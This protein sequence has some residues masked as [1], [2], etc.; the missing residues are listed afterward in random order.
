M[1]NEIIISMLVFVAGLILIIKGA[2]WITKYGSLLAKKLGVSE[3][4]I[5]ITL[6]AMATS[7][8]ELAVAIISAV[9]NVN[10]IATGTVIGSNISN[11]A[12]I[13]GLS[14]LAYPLSTKRK[15]LN[16]GFA[17]LGFS[18]LLV[19]FLF[20]G[21][22]WYEGAVLLLFFFA[23]IGYSLKHRKEI[24]TELSE[25][26][27]GP[28][29][30]TW[31][32]V[33]ICIVSGGLVVLG[34]NFMVESTVSIARGFGIPELVISM[35]II[36]LGTSLPELATSVAAAIKRMRGISLGNIIGSN[37]FN[38]A[39][40]GLSSMLAPLAVTPH[41]VFIDLPVMIG[42]TAAL[43]VFMRTGWKIT[44]KE[45]AFLV[46]VYMAFIASQFV[47]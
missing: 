13:L 6:V 15:Y 10:D 47:A 34:A 29:G 12:L 42:V 41:V 39:I 28:R 1:S 31:E 44:R 20:D 5:G 14:A 43:L 21:M 32:Y 17:T 35:I 45:G 16:Q 18:L 27:K 37:I 9:S 22:M 26:Y 8:P 11:I 46:A 36:A 40:L 19:A 23:Y 4:I 7:L 30:R 38:I 25:D 3:L 2:D 24:G 33:A